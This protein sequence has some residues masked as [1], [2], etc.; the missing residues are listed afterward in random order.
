[1][2]FYLPLAHPVG[3]CALLEF[4]VLLFCLELVR[5]RERLLETD[6]DDDDGQS[7]GEDAAFPIQ[8]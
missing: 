5:L 8:N 6:T 1:M 2:I 3:Q 7:E 4:Q